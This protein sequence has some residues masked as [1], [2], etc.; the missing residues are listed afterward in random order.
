MRSSNFNNT[1]LFF[2]YA[3]IFVFGACETIPVK[4]M[5]VILDAQELIEIKREIQSGNRNYITALR[6]LE[7]KAD[8]ALACGPFSVMDKPFIPPSG[9][10]HDYMSVGPYW[11]PDPEQPDG[12]PYIRRDGEVNPERNQYDRIPLKT[13]DTCITTLGLAYFYTGNETY[14]NHASELIKTW[15]LNDSTK[16]NPH[17]EFGQAI[18]G[19]T[20][21]RGTGIIDTRAFFRV[22]DVIWMIEKSRHWSES[23]SEG[24][25]TWFARFLDWM[26]KSKNGIDERNS[27]NNHGTWYDVI[28]ASLA[29]YT[30]QE[31][32][33]RDILNRVPGDRINL[34]I[35]PDGSQPLELTRT[36]AFHYSAMNL[37]GLFHAALIAEKLG[38]DLWNYNSQDGRSLRNALDFLLPFAT[39]EK[40]WPHA[41]L[42]GWEEDYQIMLFLCRLAAMRYNNNQYE[43]A[44]SDFPGLNYISNEINLMF[45]SKK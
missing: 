2:C 14:A 36:R 34:Q 8:Q 1:N 45:G 35:E 15:F 9:D 40:Q 33:A 12:L 10:K 24:M 44:I 22:V 42:K 6:Y 25:K 30:D 43:A 5:P 11:W 19:R 21:G 41:Q 28:A 29:V 23:D 31:D 26:L 18:P 39:G 4:N 27:K 16:M 20:D 37:Q 32:L 17:L 13:L 7:Q 38:I 3:A